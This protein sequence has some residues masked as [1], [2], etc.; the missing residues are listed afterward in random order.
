VW[1]FERLKKAYGNL[2]YIH[3][4]AEAEPHF[5]ARSNDGAEGVLDLTVIIEEGKP[6][7]VRSLKFEG[8]G[9]IAFAT[10]QKEMLVRAQDVFSSE[11]FEES[12]RRLNKLALF[13]PI[14][15]DKDVDYQSGNETAQL[16][17][18][19]RVKKRLH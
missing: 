12:I 7:I 10:L 19:I 6:F 15:A 14:D 9:D 2:G 16:A 5:R 17:I 11:R 1:L 4:T 8:N 13:E 3:Y 18:T